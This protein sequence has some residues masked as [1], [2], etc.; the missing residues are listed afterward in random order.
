[1]FNLLMSFEVWY[2]HHVKNGGPRDVHGPWLGDYLRL[3]PH[4]LGQILMSGEHPIVLAISQIEVIDLQHQNL[5]QLWSNCV[6]P[7]REVRSDQCVVEVPRDTVMT[8]RASQ[9]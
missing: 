1:M 6:Y 4:F 5:S 9:R 7:L 2:L 3:L 8:N